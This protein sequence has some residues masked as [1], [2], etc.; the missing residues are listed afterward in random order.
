MVLETPARRTELGR[1]I[2]ATP[3]SSFDRALAKAEREAHEAELWVQ[4]SRERTGR[5][6]AMSYAD[7]LKQDKNSTLNMNEPNGL[8][9]AG[10]YD[11]GHDTSRKAQ[12]RRCLGD[13]PVAPLRPGVL[14]EAAGDAVV[15][16]SLGLRERAKNAASFLE[17]HGCS[18]GTITSSTALASAHQRC[19]EAEAKATAAER[20]LQRRRTEADA[21]VAVA[22]TKAIAEASQRAG[23]AEARSAS[24][25]TRAAEAEARAAEAEAKAD[26]AEVRAKA[27]EAEAEARAAEAEARA[28]EAEVRAAEAEARAVEA[29]ATAVAA[30][31]RA[32][33]AEMRAEAAEAELSL[34]SEK[35]EDVAAATMAARL[36]MPA[37]DGA[38]EELAVNLAAAEAAQ[39]PDGGS[40]QWQ[41]DH[42]PFKWPAPGFR[43]CPTA[44]TAAKERVKGLVADLI[45]K[46]LA[47]AGEADAAAAEAEEEDE[48]LVLFTERTSALFQSLGEHFLVQRPADPVAA[49]LLVSPSPIPAA[50][51]D[52]K[53]VIEKELIE[54]ELLEDLADE[55]LI[56]VTER[57]SDNSLSVSN[58][59]HRPTDPVAAKLIGSL[60]ASPTESPAGSFAASPAPSTRMSGSWSSSDGISVDSPERAAF[61]TKLPSLSQSY[62]QDGLQGRGA[63][64]PPAALGASSASSSPEQTFYSPVASDTS[65]SS[66][67]DERELASPTAQTPP[68]SSSMSEA[69]ASPTPA[70]LSIQLLHLLFLHTVS[71]LRQLLAFLNRRHSDCEDDSNAVTGAALQVEELV[72][73]LEE[74]AESCLP[75]VAQLLQESGL[76]L[77]QMGDAEHEATAQFLTNREEPY[78]SFSAADEADTQHPSPASPAGDDLYVPFV[79]AP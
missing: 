56:L 74:E 14:D 73:R 20:A 60:D 4:R 53:G 32:G 76:K 61:R 38:W 58:G 13:S 23:R 18:R 40:R 16:R 42:S 39:C 34:V 48:E 24:A 78:V 35:V 3:Q 52:G 51:D 15:Q 27:G 71:E 28:A 11:T 49:S 5:L 41:G 70:L 26:S 62:R 36:D 47:E 6:Q 69:P 46:G 57:A 17:V 29:E 8:P 65:D 67:A 72:L 43:S 64:S 33:S 45:S 9:Y 68:A 22:I 10:S 30:E 55:E 25:E 79:P 54:E 63:Y 31:V 50:T 7:V 2:F 21:E 37:S 12:P 1:A 75:R 66:S 44:T 77:G 19:A 59:L